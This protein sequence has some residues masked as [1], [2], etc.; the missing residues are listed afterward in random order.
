MRRQERFPGSNAVLYRDDAVPPAL[1]AS[2]WKALSLEE[3]PTGQ[4]DG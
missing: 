1:V 3:A 4:A 2:V